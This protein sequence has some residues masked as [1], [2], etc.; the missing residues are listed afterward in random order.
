MGNNCCKNDLNQEQKE[1]LSTPKKNKQLKINQGTQ[2]ESLKQASLK[3]SDQSSTQTCAD[4]DLLAKHAPDPLKNKL[5]DKIPDYLSFRGKKLLNEL[6][7]FD[8]EL[9][10]PYEEEDLD[11]NPELGPY[12]QADK[13]VY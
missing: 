12:M 3:I 11:E 13:A 7:E 9:F 5:V 8:Y 4:K 6:G 10:P 1:L 2:I